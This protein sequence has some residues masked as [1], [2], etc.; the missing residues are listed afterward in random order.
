[1]RKTIIYLALLILVGIG[2]YYL[3]FDKKENPY[4]ETEAS[5]TVK[6]T[7]QIGMIYLAKSSGET[8]KLKRLASGWTVND[9]YKAHRGTLASLLRTLSLQEAI[10]PVP[11]ASHN[12]VIKSMAGNSVKV[13]VY[14]RD[15]E[16]IRTF[17][18]GG[19]GYNY[20]GNYMI[21]ENAKKPYLVNIPRFPGIVG[22]AYTT[23]IDD[24]RDR[25]VFNISADNINSIA[26]KYP[27]EPLNS[28]TLSQNGKLSVKA[29]PGAIP[30]NSPLNEKRIRDYLTFFDNINCEGYLHDIPELPAVMASVP[31]V[32]IM[33]VTGKNNYRQHVEI[34]RMPLNKRSKNM[35]SDLY[36][37]YDADR[38]Y[39]TINDNKDTVIVQAFNFGKLWR[40]AYEFYDLTTK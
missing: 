12:N 21:Q 34:Y 25:T 10:A 26:I 1:M 24:W 4:G 13:E 29:E 8:I 2:V 39:A 7:S 37:D 9:R 36:G 32:C 35:S 33:D 22:P 20:S 27:G 18:V 38:F 28:F 31:K 6:D 14:D 5:F 19:L 11:K 17:Y 40:K 3:V 15:Q 16:K 23:D 30:S